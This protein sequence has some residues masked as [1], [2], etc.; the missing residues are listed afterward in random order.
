MDTPS[1]STVMYPA[2]RHGDTISLFVCSKCG[3]FI[4]SPVTHNEWHAGIEH[5]YRWTDDY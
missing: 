5:S 3:S 2:G 4:F 1:Y